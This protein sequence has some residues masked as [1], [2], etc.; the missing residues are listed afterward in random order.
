MTN[1]PTTVVC[2]PN[3]EACELRQQPA[4][5][6]L[7]SAA[8]GAI[9][10]ARSAATSAFAGTTLVHEGQLNAQLFTV[11]AGWAFRYKTLRDGRRQILN[12]LLPGDLTGLQQQFGGEADC[13]VE[14]LTDCALCV[15]K[16]QSLMGIYS[17]QP[18]LGYD[19][20]WLAAREGN[21]VD[22]NLLSAGQR[23]AMERVAM[24]LLHLYRRMDRIGQVED[25]SILFPLTQQH[26]ADAL[27]L[28]LV[29]TNKTLRRLAVLGLHKIKGG[30]L[31]VL[32]PRAL[33]SVAEYYDTPPPQLPLL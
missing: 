29:H 8:L 3:C 30:R 28:S 18:Q 24:L 4:F 2:P 22:Q 27:G 11:Y 32:N 12:F 10:A 13:G 17:A 33:A 15:F 9:Q 16:P 26:I 19:V 14:L 1:A 25:G 5:A 20:T 31:Y 23:N 21:H 6:Q 7:S